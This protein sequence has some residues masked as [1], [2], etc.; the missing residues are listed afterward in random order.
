MVEGA[1]GG[2]GIRS[3]GLPDFGCALDSV[4][5]QSLGSGQA[6]SSVAGATHRLC[7]SSARVWGLKP[8]CFSGTSSLGPGLG[9]LFSHCS[10]VFKPDYSGICASFCGSQLSH[11]SMAPEKHAEGTMTPRKL[12]SSHLSPQTVHVRLRLRCGPSL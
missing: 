10:G 7:L 8:L 11:W 3:Q 6:L 9:P 2:E 12:N 1:Q 5:V 4:W